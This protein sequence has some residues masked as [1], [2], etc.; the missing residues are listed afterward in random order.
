MTTTPSIPDARRTAP[1]I[2]VVQPDAADDLSRFGDR[3]E[4]AG[5][6]ISTIRPYLHD[7]VPEALTADALVVLGGHMGVADAEQFPW[8]RQIQVLLKDAV[9]RRLPVLAICLGAQLLADAF[10]GTVGRGAAG[11][12]SGLTRIGWT[13]EAAD[14]ALVQHLPEPFLAC[15]FH[16]DSIDRLPES[17][18]HLGTGTLYP[19]QAFRI[20][21]A[22]GLQFHPEVTPDR[23]KSWQPE[24]DPVDAGASER[25]HAQASTF[26]ATDE[27]VLPSTLAL[28]DRFASIVRDRVAS[29]ER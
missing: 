12:E 5:L 21:S 6:R 16:F 28:A 4:D 13:G 18:V 15:N 24:A 3:L 1:E 2:L 10:G 8:L 19:H 14:D 9:E 11:L 20:G 22:W 26:A 29:G 25:F 23:F 17:A 7:A 27:A